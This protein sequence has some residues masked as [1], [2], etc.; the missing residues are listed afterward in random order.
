MERYIRNI[1]L[2]ELGESGQRKLLGSS[3]LIVGAGAL[4]TVVA[5]YLAGSGVGRIGVVD[6]DVIDITNLQRQLAFTEGDIGRGKASG[7]AAKLREINS[8]I[9]VECF[10]EKLDSLSAEV[11]FD[12]YDLIVEATDRPDSK[13]MVTETCS[14][15][16]K[17]VVLGGVAQTCGQVMSIVD[18]TDVRYRDMFPESASE[19]EYLP[20]SK[21]GI[22]G[23]LPGVTGSLQAAEV[24]K[25]L[26]GFGV[27][28]RNSMLMYD[29]SDMSFRKIEL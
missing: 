22:L 21:G 25:I 11:L 15:L 6:Y 23:P 27:P 13:Y 24:I 5:M 8:G 29:L 7:L 18:T 12:D 19:G 4:G 9:T 26:T 20:A 2:K 16:G 10:N 17:P 14:R 3:V 28:L 1:Q